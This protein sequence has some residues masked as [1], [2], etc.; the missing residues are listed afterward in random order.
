MLLDNCEHLLDACGDVITRLL[1]QCPRLTILTTSREPIGVSGEITWRVPSLSLEDEA[2]ALFTERAQRARPTFH[3]TGDDLELVVNI[4]RRLDGMPLA[5]ELA[6]ARIRALSLRQIADSL[7]D[8][9]RL[10]TGAPETPCG[11]NR[12][13]GHPWIGRMRC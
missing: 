3:A 8:R 4:C 1:N 11:A 12:P 10:L 9:F 2:V 6:A 13:Y 5:I 7:N